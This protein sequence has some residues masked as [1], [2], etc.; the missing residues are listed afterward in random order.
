MLHTVGAPHPFKEQY[1]GNETILQNE[2]S[3]DESSLINPYVSAKSLNLKLVPCAPCRN[4][5]ET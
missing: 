4:F 2:G 1:C 5:F 3:F